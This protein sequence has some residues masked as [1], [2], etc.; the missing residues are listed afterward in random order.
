M[1]IDDLLDS[2]LN[3]LEPLTDINIVYHYTNVMGLK[4]ILEDR[5]F[6]VSHARF[7]NDKTE[8][9]YTQR[10]IIN[11]LI[12]LKSEE[13]NSKVISTY[14]AFLNIMQVENIYTTDIKNVRYR[15]SQDRLP[16]FVLSFSLN[17]DSSHLWSEFNCGDGYNIGIDFTLFYNEMNNHEQTDEKIARLPS[18]VV[19]D[20]NRQ[21]ELID[22]RIAEFIQ[23]AKNYD[24]NE[25][26]NYYTRFL[27][28][29]RL[30]ANFFKDPVFYN[31]EEFRIVIYNHKNPS[32]INPQYRIK[33]NS[34]VPYIPSISY[35]TEESRILLPIK[36]VTIGPTN[37][38][39][40]AEEGLVY[41]MND[42]GYDIKKIDYKKSIIPLR[43]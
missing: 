31:D 1:N 32:Y 23:I 7:M 3:Y 27:S 10:L 30:F 26:T 9:S 2:N 39:D 20:V 28:S 18:K 6:N 15:A 8:I 11:E 33:G 22:L 41:Y 42:I 5:N 29:M 40:I 13:S 35:K 21:K 34:L 37:F 36:S 43:F 14:D 24:V 16:E 19:Y 25:L 17:E 4:G 12:R 38:S